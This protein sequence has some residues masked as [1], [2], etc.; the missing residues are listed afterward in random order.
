MTPGAP[1]VPSLLHVWDGGNLIQASLELSRIEVDVGG[2][3]EISN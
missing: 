3:S 2:L 1:H